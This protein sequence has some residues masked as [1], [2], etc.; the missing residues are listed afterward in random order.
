MADK[1][2]KTTADK[3]RAHATYVILQQAIF[4]RLI[5]KMAAIS[6]ASG[7]NQIVHRAGLAEISEAAAMAV[8]GSDKINI[9]RHRL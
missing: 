8:M 9:I 7:L 3:R 2:T 6:P 4:K 5:A 1:K